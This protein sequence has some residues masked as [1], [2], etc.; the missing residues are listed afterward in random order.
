[1]IISMT[2]F[3]A[4]TFSNDLFTLETEIKSLNSRFLDLS[5]RLPKE[6]SKYEFLIRDLIKSKIGRGKVTVSLNLTLNPLNN[7]INSIDLDALKKTAELLKEINSHVENNSPIGIN[8]LLN[9]KEYFLTHN[10]NRFE[11]D[12]EIIINS[13]NSALNNFIEMKKA[14]GVE[15]EKD[16]E[17][18]INSI[19]NSLSLIENNARTS[20]LDYFE[21]FKER[22]KKLSDDYI[23]D[24]DRFIQEIAIL[25]EKHDITEECIRLR[26]HIKIFS[27][28][29]ENNPDAGRKLNFISQEMNREVNTINSKSIS[30]EISHTGIGMKE[31]LE[32]IREQIQNIE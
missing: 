30:L 1:M 28:T 27:E 6:L 5:I 19:V 29:M 4:D 8:E 10:Q 31:E 25:S 15:L 20:V 3:G 14:E 7:S 26:S 13:T 18:R 24:K 17:F 22:A 16:L 2:G 12:E 11:L 23:D 9:L 21:K 32:K